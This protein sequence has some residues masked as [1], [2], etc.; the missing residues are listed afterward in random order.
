M[1]KTGSVALNLLYKRSLFQSLGQEKKDR[2]NGR[3]HSKTKRE[4]TLKEFFS[5]LETFFFSL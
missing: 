5:E 2:K 3:K 4:N 1:R